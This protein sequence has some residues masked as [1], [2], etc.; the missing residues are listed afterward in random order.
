MSPKIATYMGGK[1]LVVISATGT[2]LGVLFTTFFVFIGLGNTGNGV[3]GMEGLW[4]IP[5]GLLGIM[6]P[7]NNNGKKK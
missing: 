4:L 6:E 2:I 3:D 1:L 7:C 5:G